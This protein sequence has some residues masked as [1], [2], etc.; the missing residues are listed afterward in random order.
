M[1]PI[2][3][4]QIRMW[5]DMG[6]DIPIEEGTYWINNQVVKAYDAE[7]GNLCNLY[8]IKVNDD[9][10]MSFKKHKDYLKHANKG[11]E[12][13]EQT[14]QRNAAHLD[15]LEAEAVAL[16]REA[17]S[18]YP[19]HHRIVLTSTGKD[20]V[21]VEHI[22]QLA[23]FNA[24]QTVF[25]NTTLDVAD[26][27]QIVKRNGYTVTNPSEGF[28]QYIKRMNFIPARFS[29][30]CCTIFKEGNFKNYFQNYDKLLIA[31]G[32]RNAES[33]NRADYGDYTHNP[34]YPADWISVLPIRKFEDED[35]W[36]YILSRGLEFNPKYRKGYQRVGCAIACPYY[37]KST[38]VLDKYWYPN[39]YERWHRILDE[40]FVQNARWTKLNCTLEEYHSCWNG[41]LLRAEATEE[42]INEFAAHKGI[43]P[44]VAKQY[45]NKTCTLCPDGAKTK[46]IRQ[47]EVL[48]M[49]MKMLGR[50]TETFYCKKHLMQKFNWTEDGWND[51]VRSF[52][53]QG[54]ELF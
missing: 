20:S 9:L 21:V 19:D 4:E 13:W 15:E 39:L 14:V 48:A 3:N 49:N 53:Q 52:T 41:G 7:T 54:C 45:F 47:T 28:Y 12:K 31:S 17:K 32:V 40:V 1:Q 27:Y 10:T 22:A 43:Q 5:H 23:G 37:T 36:L 38:W 29:R 24:G 42:V 11:F 30:G 51:K 33:P 6:L 2:W 34:K 8:R 26:T 25:N 16:L 50:N 18:L 44:D 46:N 35:V